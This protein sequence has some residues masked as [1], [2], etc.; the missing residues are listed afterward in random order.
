MLFGR[1]PL[2]FHCAGAPVIQ[3]QPGP[4]GQPPRLSR[5]QFSPVAPGLRALLGSGPGRLPT[6]PGCPVRAGPL[7]SVCPLLHPGSGTTRDGGTESRED[8]GWGH[9]EPGRR[10]GAPGASTTRAGAPGAGTTRAGGTGSRDEGWGHREPGRPRLG[11]P[12]AGTTQAGGTGSQ[13]SSDLGSSSP[14]ECS[15]C[16]WPCAEGFTPVSI[17]Y[18]PWPCPGYRSPQSAGQETEV[19]RA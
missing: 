12:G 9:R 16:A 13:G 4:R 10:L 18:S 7:L 19:R 17:R 8:P 1:G 2:S 3:L 14:A 15:P 11:A 5:P 6:L